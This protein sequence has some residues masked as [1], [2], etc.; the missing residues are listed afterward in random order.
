MIG[1]GLA[2]LGRPEYLNIRAK[3]VHDKS[4]MAFKQN[5]F[6]VL[7]SAYNNGIRFF[8]TAPSYGKG[9]EFLKEWHSN[10]AYSD[11]VLST[12]WGYT[13]VANWELGYS[14][15][16]EIKE[17]S[18]SKLIEQW[19]ISKTLLP[20]LKVYQIHSATF[21]SGVLQNSE[22][23]RKLFEI[24]EATGLKIGLT[25]SGINQKDIIREA[26][27]V[28]V[29]G[30]SLF[31][32]FQVTYNVFEQDVFDV[33]A[34]VNKQGKFIIIKEG[35]ANGR[36]FLESKQK[37][38]LNKIANKYQVGIDAVA[39]RFC[40]DSIPS[41]IV[42]SGASNIEQLKEN[43]KALSFKLTDDEITLLKS[44][45]ISPEDYWRERSALSWN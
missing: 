19:N 20:N 11:V 10:R 31:D 24:K 37:E 30:L 45:K 8:D 13:Y 25:A 12:K 6:N 4:E 33:L 15:A 40:I 5:T 29:N 23:L 43:L 34:E 9:E 26:L 38:N 27:S 42:L 1:L 44:F 22:V 18:L 21:E 17:H 36:V 16:H 35:L 3:Q 32:S 41:N 28:Q 14:G 39:L 2:A 7:D